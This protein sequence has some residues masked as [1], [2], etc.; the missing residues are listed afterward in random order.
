[1]VRRISAKD[2]TILT[3]GE[4]KFIKNNLRRYGN[5]YGTICK[6]VFNALKKAAE[7]GKVVSF[8]GLDELGFLPLAYRVPAE[9]DGMSV[10][11]KRKG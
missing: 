11:M 4:I 5:S 10:E 8:H 3:D 6:L 2:N 9:A 1:M 7:A